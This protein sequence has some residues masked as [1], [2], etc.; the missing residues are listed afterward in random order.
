MKGC[1]CC[2]TKESCPFASATEGKAGY[3]GRILLMGN[4]NVGKSAIFSRLT[5]VHALSSNYPGTTVGFT[6]GRLQLGEAAYR[7]I[8]A[9][10][11]YTLEPTNEAEE[12]ACR[13]LDE[14]ADAVIVVLDATAL[15]RSLFLALQILEKGLPT[16]LVLNMSDEARHKGIEIDEKALEREVGVPVVST[17]AVSGVG[18]K[19]LLR[20]IGEARIVIP[21]HSSNEERWQRIGEIVSRVQ[22][23]SHRHHTFKDRIEDI[24]VHPLWGGILGAFVLAISFLSIRYI[25]EGLINY[26]LD[27]IFDAFWLP[28]LERISTALGG[29]GLLHSLLIGSLIEG[30]IDLEQSF[31]VLSTGV[32]VPIVMVFPYVLAFYAALG[33]LEDIGYLPRLAVIFDALLHRLGLHGYAIVPNLLGLGCNVP[34]IMATRVLESER[35]RFIASTLISVAVPCAGLQAMILGTLGTYGLKYVLTVYGTLFAA[36]LILGRILHAALPGYSPELIVEIP[37]YRLPRLRGFTTKLFFRAKEFFTDAIPLVFVGIL[38]AGLL[39]ESGIIN[40]LTGAAAPIFDG[41]LGLPPETAG[42]ILLGFLRKDVA[43]GFLLPL[44][45]EPHQLVVASVTLS[46]TFPCIATF[47][48]LLK[49][50]GVKRLLEALAIMIIVALAA[51][52]TLNFLFSLAR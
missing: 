20:A 36:W 51:G 6:E 44:G 8:D 4:P 21:H 41:V 1:A 26:V 27:P 42:P 12:V 40:V 9:P 37:P 28:L 32:Y 23:I 3:K 2:Q 16:V 47:V 25:G 18:I 30:R 35:E 50:L 15:E 39:Y 43:V 49:E 46:M 5:G 48:V 52:G 17:V 22:R 19:E 31:G 38:I 11:A 7:L 14:G 45:L 24:S 33:I 29:E 34:G 10:G 13:I